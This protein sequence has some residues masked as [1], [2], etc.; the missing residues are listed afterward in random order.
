MLFCRSSSVVAACNFRFGFWGEKRPDS[1]TYD[2]M[3]IVELARPRI[4][5]WVVSLASVCVC[6]MRFFFIFSSSSSSSLT[7]SSHFVCVNFVI[8]LFWIWMAWRDVRWS[9]SV[10]ASLC[11]VCVCGACFVFIWFWGQRFYWPITFF[12]FTIH[13]WAHST[14]GRAKWWNA[15]PN[16]C[17]KRCQMCQYII[18]Y[19]FF[20]SL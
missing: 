4:C 8:L 13:N 18:I 9:M 20:S 15:P 3:A 19:L 7:L 17:A 12:A 2:S 11:V 1:M 6:K 5:V 16:K 10:L 14:Q